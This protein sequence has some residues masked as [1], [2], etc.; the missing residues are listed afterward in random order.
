MNG[1]N[2]HL[3]GRKT[4][5]GPWQINKSRAVNRLYFVNSGSA[6]VRNAGVE[7]RLTA[8]NFYI[9]PQCHDFTPLFA[10]NFDHTY[11]DYSSPRLL[12]PSQ[13]VEIDASVLAAQHFFTFVNTLI[14]GDGAKATPSAMQ[15]L[16]AGFLTAIEDAGVPM[17]Y[18]KNTVIAEAAGVIHRYFATITTADLARRFNFNESYFIRLFRST[19]GISPMK[20]IRACRVMRGGE[21][22][23]SGMS[24]E[25][26]SHR[27]GFSS[28]SA[29]YKA[30]KAELGKSPSELKHDEKNEGEIK[31]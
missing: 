16:L 2:L 24:V 19:L 20:Y 27:C 18:S 3:Y 9:I 31:C 14:E 13:V 29:F 6:V 25:D 23:R 17:P 30:V 22:L 28:P 1:I 10:D 12:S 15:A 26:A 8:G 5:Q 21:L 4:M 11:F 7:K